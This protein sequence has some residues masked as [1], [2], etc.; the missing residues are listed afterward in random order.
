MVRFAGTGSRE[1]PTVFIYNTPILPCEH[2]ECVA[3]RITAI[4]F[5]VRPILF[6]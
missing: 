1:F 2:A 3:K 6:L 4:E 5:A